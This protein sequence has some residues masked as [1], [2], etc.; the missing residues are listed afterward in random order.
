MEPVLYTQYK[1]EVVP[2]LKEEFGYKNIMQVPKIKKVIVNVGYGRHVKDKSYIDK[3]ENT[4][5]TITGQKPV[6]NKARKSISNFKIRAGMP[7]GASVTLRGKSMYD[8]L[9][10]LNHLALP[11]VRDFRGISKK[12]F[13]K[14]GNYTLG[15]KEQIAFPE[16]GAETADFVHGME[17]TV[18]TSANSKK[19]GES[20][21]SKLGFPFKAK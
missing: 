20:L 14:Q 15:L 11:R 5:A 10:R 18:V 2:A 16:L 17:I 1:K 8:F 3:V 4:L 21:L 7:I 6:H 9:Y 12:G 19:E 13:D